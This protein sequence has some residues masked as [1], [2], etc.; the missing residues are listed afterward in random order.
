MLSSEDVDPRLAEEAELASFGVPATNAR[1]RLDIGAPRARDAGHLERGVRR[2]DVRIE[3]RADA[4][5]MSVGIL[6][7]AGPIFFTTLSTRLRDQ[8]VG[9]LPVG[10]ALVGAGRRGGVVPAP[11]RRGP[12]MEVLRAR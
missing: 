7:F 8:R 9:E 1:T 4:V 11:A 5:T 6:P 2:R 10:R 3:P 12:R